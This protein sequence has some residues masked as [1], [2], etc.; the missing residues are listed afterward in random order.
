MAFPAR[1]C[2]IP[3]VRVCELV[4]TLH[5]VVPIKVCIEPGCGAQASGRGGRC[6]KHRRVN[7]GA[8][9]RRRGRLDW[10]R[11]WEYTRRRQLFNE[12]LCELKGP[13]CTTIATHVDHIDPEGPA[14]DFANLQSTCASCHGAKTAGE[15]ASRQRV[16]R[17]DVT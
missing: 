3:R 2:G 1:L 9:V 15:V 8:I 4:C 5:V 12:P 16:T 11:R 13:Q 10:S 7:D 17:D 6:A 14:F